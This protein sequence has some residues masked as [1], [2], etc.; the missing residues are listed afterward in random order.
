MQGSTCLLYV[1][2]LLALYTV[3]YHFFSTKSSWLSNC[4]SKSLFVQTQIYLLSQN[5]PV[6]QPIRHHSTTSIALEIFFRI[7]FCKGLLWWKPLNIDLVTT[8]ICIPCRSPILSLLHSHICTTTL[9]SSALFSSA[10]NSLTCIYW[11]ALL[12]PPTLNLP[13]SPL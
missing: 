3:V 2:Y 11:I 9:F 8:T 10:G 13:I 5:M 6:S 4:D 1:L 12:E 7:L